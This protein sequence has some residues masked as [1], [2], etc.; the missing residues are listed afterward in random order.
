MAW[1]LNAQEKRPINHDDYD[2]WKS[3]KEYKISDNG[4]YAV[5][6]VNP[7]EGDGNLFIRNIKNN[8]TITISRGEKALIS[9]SEVFVAF[10]IK[11]Q[12]DTV[13]KAKLK[14]VKKDKMPK[15]SLGIYFTKTGQIKKY[16]ELKEFKLSE[17]DNDIL[18]AT[19]EATKKVKD[20]T[21]KKKKKTKKKKSDTFTL[22]LFKAGSDS[23]FSFH[24]VSKFDLSKNGELLSFY[25]STNDS[26]DSVFVY[27][28][29]S[30]DEHKHLIYSDAGYAAS[31]GTD[32]KGTQLAF[33]FS[34]DTAKNK[35]YKLIYF[36]NKTIELGVERFA[37]FDK[38]LSVSPD[39]KIY[40][41]DR[42]DELYFGLRKTP[43]PEPKDTLTKDEKVSVDIWNWKDD[44]LQPM[45]L[46]RLKDEK[47]R[48]YTVVYQPGV[49]KITFIGKDDDGNFIE[50]LRID[51]KAIGNLSLASDNHKY[52]QEISWDGSSYYDYYLFDRKSGEK[53][54]VLEKV[55]S[56]V[57]LST[58]Q[59]FIAWYNIA[60]SNWYSYDIEAGKSI[61]LTAN[62]GVNFYYELNDVPNEARAYG[63]AGWDEDG[64][65]YVYDRYDIWKLNPA[66]GS[67]SINFTASYGRDNNLELRYVKL[68]RDLRYLPDNKMFKVFNFENKKAGFANVDKKGR[69]KKLIYT[70][71]RFSYPQKAKNAKVLL[72]TKEDFDYC[73]EL[74]S[75][76][77]NFRKSQKLSDLNAQM[78]GFL[79]GS[80]ELISYP[81]YDGDTMQGMLYKPANFDPNKKYP[82]LVYFYERYSQMLHRFFKP[83]PIR[84]VINFSYYTS[85][86]YLIFVPDIKYKVGYPGKSAVNC[87]V[88]GT[89]YLTDKYSFIDKENIGIQGQSWGGYQTAYIV[90][91]TDI[92]KAA[93]A[94]APVSNMTSAYGGIRWGSGM[95]RAFQYEE[96]QSRIGGTL[97]EKTDL[98]LQNSPVFYAP[99]VHTPLLMM[100][101]DKDGAVPWYQG[102]EYFNALRRLHKPVWMLVYNGAP[103]NL[104]RRADMKDLTVRMQQFFD[105]FLKGDAEPVWMKYGVPAI[106]KGKDFGLKLV[107]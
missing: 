10:R 26:I 72:W 5:Y 36:N 100:H 12:F 74:F 63:F 33:S 65:F 40:F 50:N 20:T 59:D 39:A 83:A 58:L 90:T 44:Y 75:S 16:A 4:N 46:K 15:D 17:E 99:N 21:N 101:N 93:M 32:K 30:L 88:S 1:S 105:H 98:Y 84:S 24:K 68:D 19:F 87:I 37:D 38:N 104:S 13:R 60:D 91:Q 66:N 25:K 106:D 45:Q 95:S 85:N 82:M 69:V 7:Q 54:L 94:G 55:A 61:N 23:V 103:H 62:L 64:S 34:A 28:F 92:Y 107:E 80:V 73:T 102:I 96:T 89:E 31:L 81:T 76:D 6:T 18:V 43:E 47:K 29:Q 70:D 53:K 22:K 41:N 52:R 42:G 8:Q 86:G 49:D 97:W 3:I 77:M 27:S 71:K 56:T 2:N 9:P 78:K 48:S 57:S 35:A 11:P 79:W 14:K 67:K 51:K